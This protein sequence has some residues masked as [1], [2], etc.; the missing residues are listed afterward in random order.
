MR[1]EKISFLCTFRRQQMRISEFRS[2]NFSNALFDVD[3]LAFANSA[4]ISS[5]TPVKSSEVTKPLSS[6]SASQATQKKPL[7]ELLFAKQVFLQCPRALE[8]LLG[9]LGQARLVGFARAL[10]ECAQLLHL[11]APEACPEH[12]VFGASRV[13]LDH[14]H[15]EMVENPVQLCVVLEFLC[16]ARQPEAVLLHRNF[17]SRRHQP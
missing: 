12:G 13:D 16:L 15:E 1:I 11:P 17:L 7:H 6:P 14:F 3:P 2:R 4:L 10:G 9:Q 8:E 5:K